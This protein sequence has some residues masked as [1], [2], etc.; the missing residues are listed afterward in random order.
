MKEMDLICQKYKEGV[1]GFKSQEK[2]KK[3][4]KNMAQ[5]HMRLEP[6]LKL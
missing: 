5:C 4:K 6:N 1:K 3:N 2:H